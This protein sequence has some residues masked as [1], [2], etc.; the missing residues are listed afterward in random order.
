MSAG[1]ISGHACEEDVNSR[2]EIG[3]KPWDT[4]IEMASDFG[5]IILAGF[6]ICM[7]IL[8]SWFCIVHAHPHIRC[9]I[10]G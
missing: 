9:I 7:F 4:R 10:S 1:N 8:N 3:K 5:G 6:T 2:E